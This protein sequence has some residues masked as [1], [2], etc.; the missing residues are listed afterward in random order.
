[1]K[2]LLFLLLVWFY[3][4]LGFGAISECLTDVYYANGMQVDE[5]NAT[6]STDL[7]MLSILKERYGG[8]EIKR[9]CP[10]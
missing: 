9:L 4:L 1:M 2:K 6:A 10:H 7:L 8:S 3:P 5:G